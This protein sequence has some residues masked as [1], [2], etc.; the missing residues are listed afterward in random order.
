MCGSSTTGISVFHQCC[1]DLKLTLVPYQA[2]HS[3]PSIDR[4]RGARSQEEVRKRGGWLSRQSMARY[5]KSGRLAATWRKLDLQTQLCCTMA[6]RYIYHSWLRTKGQYF[7][8]FFSGHGGV[9]RAIRSLGLSTR[10]WELKHGQHCDLTHSNVLFKIRQD[11]RKG[12]ILG[13][14]LA[15]SAATFARARDRSGIV[16]TEDFPWGLSGLPTQVAKKVHDC[17]RRIA[18]VFRITGWLE[19]HQIPWILELPAS[20]KAWDLRRLKALCD[21][22]HTTVVAADF[23]QFGERWRARVVLLAS[24]IDELDLARCSRLCSGTSGL[25]STGAWH[26]SPSGHDRDSQPYPPRLCHALASA[27]TAHAR[28]APSLF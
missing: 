17:N 19:H 18:A 20:S 22:P 3:G 28:I 5:E 7:A 4:A 8:D 24:R 9:S 23:C 2:R 14:M 10:E 1:Q 12:L 26:V 11:I 15:P 13:A 16:R 25:C 27:L 6:E 21:A